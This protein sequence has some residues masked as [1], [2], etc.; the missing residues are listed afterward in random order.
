MVLQV[1]AFMDSCITFLSLTIMSLTRGTLRLLV[2]LRQILNLHADD[3]SFT[4]S[5]EV[6][7]VTA[8]TKA[9]GGNAAK[10]QYA[11]ALVR[12]RDIT[13]VIVPGFRL[14]A[15]EEMLMAIVGNYRIVLVMAGIED[16]RLAAVHTDFESSNLSL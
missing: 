1:E 14:F 7:V 16:P 4:I 3:L 11:G 15:L 6:A 5:P 8:I 12:K 13:A 9:A 2:L 10:G